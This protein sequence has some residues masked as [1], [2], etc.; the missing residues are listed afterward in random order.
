MLRL[1][2]MD[3][4][5]NDNS[6]YG[7]QDFFIHGFLLDDLIRSRQHI[8]WN[9]QTDLLCRFEIDHELELGRLLH[10]EIG[11]FG[12]FQDLVHVHSRTAIEVS[13][14]RPVGHETTLIDKRLVWVTRI[15]TGLTGVPTALTHRRTR[16]RT[17]ISLRGFSGSNFRHSVTHSPQFVTPFDRLR[18]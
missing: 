10:W 4:C 6:E 11:G 3:K 15:R 9:R 7:D 14:V 2:R 12:S 1:G 16:T 18:L 5:E 8:R 17:A 13:G